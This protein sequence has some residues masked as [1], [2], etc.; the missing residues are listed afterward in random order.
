MRLNPHIREHKGFTLLELTI[1]IVIFGILAAVA[2]PNYLNL[3]QNSVDSLATGLANQIT[4]ASQINFSRGSTAIVVNSCVTGAGLVTLPTN[5]T[6]ADPTFG[7]GT[8]T[9]GAPSSGCTLTITH[10]GITSTAA[11]FTTIGTP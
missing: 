9:S 1:V 10:N 4:K 3:R 11:P 8:V 2:I 7:G 6:V 5:I